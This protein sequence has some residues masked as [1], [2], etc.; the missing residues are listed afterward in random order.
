MNPNEH[1]RSGYA[2]SGLRLNRAFSSNREALLTPK[3]CPLQPASRVWRL[4]SQLPRCLSFWRWS[5][6][7]FWSLRLDR[8][9]LLIPAPT[10]TCGSRRAAKPQQTH[11]YGRRRR[12]A[13][14]DTR[15]A[16]LWTTPP[17]RP[18]VGWSCL[19]KQCSLARYWLL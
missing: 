19:S 9:A 14:I 15:P 3:P 8:V 12:I 13:H 17:T 5:L 18:P 7:R 2:K 10:S 16:R 11:N 4:D 6:P 1:V